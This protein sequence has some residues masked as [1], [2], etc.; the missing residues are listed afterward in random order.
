M[1]ILQTTDLK[2]YY[3]S[4]DTMVRALDGVN[5]SVEDGESGIFV[6]RIL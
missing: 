5:L 6:K 2:K 4:G 3:G 1:Q